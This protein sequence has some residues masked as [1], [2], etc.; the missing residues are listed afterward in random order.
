MKRL[1]GIAISVLLVFFNIFELV[2]AGFYRDAHPNAEVHAWILYF[3]WASLFASIIM[4]I[5]ALY[6]DFAK[7]KKEKFSIIILLFVVLLMGFNIYTGLE[8]YNATKIVSSNK[9]LEDDYISSE[10]YRGIYLDELNEDINAEMETM[11]YIGRDDCKDC[12][13]FEK[14]F[15]KLLKKYYVEMPTYYTT[16]DRNGKRSKEMYDLL[17]K[18]RIE[19]VP[20][21]I[22]V[23]KSKLLKIWADPITQLDEIEKYL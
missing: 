22:M 7:K 3:F 8:Y 15:A 4:L 9:S 17:E 2:H 11:I 19:S 13:E 16:K 20:C 10:F 12:I 6:Y 21:V 5:I 18:Y 1:I 23:K 14:K